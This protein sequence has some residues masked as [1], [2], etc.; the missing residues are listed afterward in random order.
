MYLKIAIRNILRNKRRTFITLITMSVGLMFFI[1]FDSLFLGIDKMLIESII[2]YSDSSIVIYSKEYDENKK[3]FP[4]DKPIKDIKKI[5]N[6]VNQIPEIETVTP[7]TQFVGDLVYSG[8][9]KYITVTVIDAFSDEQVFDFKKSIKEGN[10]FT[11]DK[12]YELLIGYNLAKDL[13]IKI[14]D[15]VT[16]VT[17][18][19]YDTY[20]ALDFIV[21]GFIY[22]TLP[23]INELSV[24]IT[25]N[26]AKE[27]LEIENLY[28]SLHIKVKWYK[29][30]NIKNYTKKVEKIV[31]QI[32]QYL[33][34]EYKVYSFNELNKEFVLLMKQKKISSF[35]IIFMLLLI[36]AVGI[37]NT[38][39]MS[40][41]ERIKE[42]GILMAIGLKPKQ[43]RKLFL[44]EGMLIGS[45]GSI[46]GCFLGS[47]IN[48]FLVRYGY[49]LESFYT[50]TA[51]IKGTD[52]AMP[53]WGTI[54]GVWN[55]KFFILCFCFGL[56]TA[57]LASYYPARYAS[58]LQPTNC[59]KFM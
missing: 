9:S 21:T 3:S 12:N 44:L 34:P 38:I 26:P 6:F 33:G 53:I 14:N 47:F 39:L 8:K 50:R 41:Y 52:L 57:M 59:L 5:L 31:E 29:I 40:V 2:K 4:L 51:G 49:N 28:N 36:S 11:N 32:S 23:T 43:I 25:H 19:K 35:I 58:K 1:F 48:L 27:L 17:K 54:Y 20:N 55:L 22:T 42:I 45:I 7:R 18:T 24:I 16:I 56:I 10:Y 37:T 46:L 15:I 30:E 13:N